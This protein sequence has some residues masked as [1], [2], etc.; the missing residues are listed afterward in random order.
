MHIPG[1]DSGVE[2]GMGGAAGAGGTVEQLTP[3]GDGSGGGGGGGGVPLP[4]VL[5]ADT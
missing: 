3:D 5:V 1:D 4:G 2:P